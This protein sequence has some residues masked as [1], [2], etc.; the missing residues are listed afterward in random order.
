MNREVAAAQAAVT[1]RFGCEPRP[2]LPGEKLG[3]SRNT[4]DGVWPLNGLR[5]PV[6]GSTCG[7]Y[8]W[9]G[10]QLPED[11][12]FFVPLHVE[13]LVE[14]NSAA[15]KYLALPPGWRFLVAPGYEDV[16]FD[17]TLVE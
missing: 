9:A 10:D 16:W 6:A 2:P 4:R 1:E 11:D 7:W 5:H 15:V 17:S 14:W 3:V 12:D 13:H 8:I